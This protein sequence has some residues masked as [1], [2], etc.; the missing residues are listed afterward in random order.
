MRLEAFI[1]ANGDDMCESLAEV[2]ADLQDTM[3]ANPEEYVDSYTGDDGEPSI[4][5]RLCVDLDASDRTGSSGGTWC[6]RTG[7]VDYDPRISQFCA[8]SSVGPDTDA[9]ELLAELIGQ[10]D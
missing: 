6:F 9:E 4:D 7:V 2:V 10:L 3:D 5:V 8:A 1:E